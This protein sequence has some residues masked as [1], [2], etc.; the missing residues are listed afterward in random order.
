MAGGQLGESNAAVAH[1]HGCGFDSDGTAAGHRIACVDHHVHDG[2]FGLGRV[3]AGVAGMVRE[4]AFDLDLVGQRALDHRH[5]LF[6]H[7]VD[8]DDPPVEPLLAREG[9]HLL[10]QRT[11]ALR[12]LRDSLDLT[13]RLGEVESLGLFE[14]VLQY[15]GE[16][17]D[18]GQE[19]VEIMRDPAAQLADRL[20]LLRLAQRVLGIASAA[21]VELRPEIIDELAVAIEHGG[22]EQR[23]PETC[24]ALLVVQY[25]DGGFAAFGDRAADLGHSVP[26]G[27]WTLHQP[28]ILPDQFLG[29]VAGHVQEGRIGEDDR[30]VRRVRVGHDHGHARRPH[31]REEDRVVLVAHVRIG[32]CALQGGGA[33]G[34]HVRTIVRHISSL[35]IGAHYAGP[36][37]NVQSPQWFSGLLRTK[38]QVGSD[39]GRRNRRLAPLVPPSCRRIGMSR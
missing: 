6:D 37:L 13:S 39:G 11:A 19:I 28:A 29:G 7:L 34:G 33:A 24:A 4:A 12:S 2:E 15:V 20:H 26:V 35:Y 27:V 16:A 36:V 32:A 9:E 14:P 5:E 21:D 18:H 17:L 38:E 3:D 1:G 31:R 22:D 8:V 23:V 10:G 30:M 25:L